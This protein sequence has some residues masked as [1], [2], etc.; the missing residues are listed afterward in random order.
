MLGSSLLSRRNWL[1]TTSCGFGYMALASMC[2]R[3]AIAAGSSYQ[4]PLAPKTPHFTPRAK[5]VIFLCMRGGPT[6]VDTFDYKPA[7]ARNHGRSVSSANAQG[8]RT[9][10]KSPWKFNFS[11]KSGL[12]ISELFPHVA[13]HA[14]DLC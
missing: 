3:E 6:H 8:A 1:K 9:L 7:L 13:R 2:S 12:P 5:R 10:M 14:D 4:N 11:G